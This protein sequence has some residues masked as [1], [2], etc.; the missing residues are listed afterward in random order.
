MHKGFQVTPQPESRKLHLRDPYNLY[1]S[2][3]GGIASLLHCLLYSYI[4]KRYL[5]LLPL[6]RQFYDL[7]T[8]N[9]L[10]LSQAVR[11]ANKLTLPHLK[12]K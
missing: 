10:L 8:Q 3:E 12:I 6:F 7:R 1:L 4:L 11:S 5:Q 2:P 9:C